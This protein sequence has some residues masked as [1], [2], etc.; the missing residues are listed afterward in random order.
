GRTPPSI[1]ARSL[2]RRTCPGARRGRSTGAPSSGAGPPCP[3]FDRGV[4]SVARRA[5]MVA[6]VSERRSGRTERWLRAGTLDEIRH[7]GVVVVGGIAVFVGP[8]GSEPG[9]A[10]VDN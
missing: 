7:R 2:A 8:E 4:E 6:P 9:V 5:G 3:A 1:I 10:A